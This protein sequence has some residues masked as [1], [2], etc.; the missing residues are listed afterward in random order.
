[1]DNAGDMAWYAVYSIGKNP[2]KNNQKL[3][4]ITGSEYNTLLIGKK[5]LFRFRK[6][7]YAVSALDHNWNEGGL[8]TTIPQR[9]ITLRQ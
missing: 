9:G 3:I 7:F 4:G 6:T 5:K 8:S 1:M 2:E